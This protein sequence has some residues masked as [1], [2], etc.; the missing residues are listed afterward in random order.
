[1]CEPSPYARVLYGSDLAEGKWMCLNEICKVLFAVFAGELLH[2][3]L[4]GLSEFLR[5]SY[6][7]QS[8]PRVV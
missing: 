5:R 8:L 6:D 4:Y 7:V 1:M 3:F 2:I